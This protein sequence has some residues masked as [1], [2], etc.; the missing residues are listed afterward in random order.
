MVWHR[1]LCCINGQSSACSSA[2][3][4]V[5]EL[6]DE[7]LAELRNFLNIVGT[8]KGINEMSELDKAADQGIKK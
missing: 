3:V 4:V 2:H 5:I 8:T 7:Q 1:L 6:F